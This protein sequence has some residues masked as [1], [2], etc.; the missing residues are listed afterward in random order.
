[1]LQYLPE[2]FDVGGLQYLRGCHWLAAPF[3]ACMCLHEANFNIP[4]E[5]AHA[6]VLYLPVFFCTFPDAL[7]LYIII[8]RICNDRSNNDTFCRASGADADYCSL[9]ARSGGSERDATFND[10]GFTSGDTVDCV[11]RPADSVIN[12]YC[13]SCTVSNRGVRS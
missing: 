6:C 4:C 2:D 3:I 11:Q 10:P 9:Q 5:G 1:V 12:Q 13:G 7:C 8:G